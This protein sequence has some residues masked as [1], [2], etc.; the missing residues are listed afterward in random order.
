MSKSLRT[1][2]TAALG[3]IA[4]LVVAY[5]ATRK[6]ITTTTTTGATAG[7]SSSSGNGAADII[8]ESRDLIDSLRGLWAGSASDPDPYSI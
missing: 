7:S 5:F 6:R 8:R 3:M 4:V 1:L 2:V